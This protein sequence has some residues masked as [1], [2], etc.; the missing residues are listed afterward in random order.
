MKQFNYAEELL[1]E[2]QERTRRLEELGSGD[3][4]G[5]RP[6]WMIQRKAHGKRDRN[7]PLV[8]RQEGVNK[9]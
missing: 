9:V 5:D 6:Q 3:R 4:S 7:K 2:Y 1:V 8:A